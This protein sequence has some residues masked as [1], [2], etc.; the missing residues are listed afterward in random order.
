MVIEF[1]D[2]P[3]QLNSFFGEL[4]GSIFTPNNS[5]GSSDEAQRLANELY[6][7]Q[8]EI[9]KQKSQKN[10]AIGVAAILGCTAAYLGFKSS[11]K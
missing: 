3:P 8:Q 5:Q 2:N 6:Y 11:K 1:Q 10:I 4:I 9:E 7:A